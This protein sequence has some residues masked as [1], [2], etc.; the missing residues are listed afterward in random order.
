CGSKFHNSSSGLTLE[1]AE[2]RTLLIC[3]NFLRR[4]EVK[5]QERFHPNLWIQATALLGWYQITANPESF[6]DCSIDLRSARLKPRIALQSRAGLIS[7]PRITRMDQ[8]RR[9]L[10]S[11]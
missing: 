10:R 8:R 9:T 7:S 3:T 2:A 6:R 5:S 11:P 4:I 1:T